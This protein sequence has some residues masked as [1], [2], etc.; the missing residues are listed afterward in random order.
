MAT[1]DDIDT[2]AAVRKFLERRVVIDRD[3]ESI[4]SASETQS[5]LEAV[6]L[7]FLLFP[8]TALSFVL[9]AKNG[10]QQLLDTDL[11]ILGFMLEAVADVENPSVKA[12][13]LSDLVEAQ[14]ALVE[15]DRLG[16]VGSEIK[17]FDRYNGAV[18]RFLDRQLSKSLKRRR[19]REFERTGS[20][21]KQDLFSSLAAFGESHRSV[22]ERLAVLA[23]S[24]NDFQSVDLTRTVAVKTVARVRASLRKL[25]RAASRG[26]VSNTSAAVELLSGAAALSSISN[27]RQVFD[28]TVAT[29]LFPSERDIRISAAPAF[30][31]A[32][33]SEA[34]VDLT[35]V[36]TPW[37]FQITANPQMSGPSFSITLPVSGASGRAY[38]TS[39]REINGPTFDLSGPTNLY[40]ELGGLPAP[41]NQPADV[42]TV[43]L[44]AGASIPVATVVSDINAALGGDG[45][46]AELSPG[47]LIIYG[48]SSVTYLVIHSDRPGDFDISG[49]YVPAD[50]S[51]HEA[52]GFTADRKSSSIGL[53]TAEDLVNLTSTRIT[54]VTV[55]VIDGL[56]Q[57][58][59][60]SDAPLS[61]LSF[62]GVASEFG[63]AGL[64]ESLPGHLFLVEG[65]EEVDPTSLGVFV[66]S[67]V[68]VVDPLGT[69]NLSAPISRIE[70]SALHFDVPT[71][72]RGR[73]VEVEIEAPAVR[74]V[75]ALLDAIRSYVRVFDTDDR[76]VQQVLS[77]LL[78]RPTLAQINDARLVLLSIKSKLEGL[79]AIL[80]ATILRDDQTEFGVV[81]AQ[82]TSSL[83]E[84]GMDRGLDLLRQGNFSQFFGLTSAT[85]SRS[86]R[87]LTA[88]EAVGRNDFPISSLEEDFPETTPLGST[89]DESI[90]TGSELASES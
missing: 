4:D 54:D 47:R 3:D 64:Y 62:G 37:V 17:A 88:I 67:V 1:V 39:N 53:F 38:I 28:P 14:T 74:A 45:V 20:E 52:L 63:F 12:S 68:T 2:K 8:Q 48:S 90:L 15:V 31:V 80:S 44:S 49:N 43:A 89:P 66:G 46:C 79:R 71:L 81:A 73:D 42:R 34:V 27:V 77:P 25:S 29:G 36:S 6:A 11:R 35:G 16:R 60:S 57:F 7:S 10:L 69:R 26:S 84:R 78:S 83:E 21:A 76:A 85:A 18:N 41:A 65:G 86:G 51:A 30:A 5:I 56:P 58:E 72:P 23:N 59:S 13:N 55:S 50:A 70:G 87:F 82:I 61:S 22:I 32:R 9:V 40:I 24:V 33:G 75:Q 19:R